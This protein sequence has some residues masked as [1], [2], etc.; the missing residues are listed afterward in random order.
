MY[1]KK[2]FWKRKAFEDRYEIVTESG[3]WIWTGRIALAGYGVMYVNDTSG[4][5]GAHRFAYENR[6]G[7]IPRDMFVCHRC[8]VRACVNPNHLFLGTPKMNSADMVAKN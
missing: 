4:S 5:M 2:G 7:P 8:D 1:V 6:F 3:C